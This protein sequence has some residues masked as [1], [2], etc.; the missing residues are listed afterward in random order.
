MFIITRKWCFYEK[1][2]PTKTIQVYKK[3]DCIHF[4][5]AGDRKF[6]HTQQSAGCTA[7]KKKIYIYF[8]IS[9]DVIFLR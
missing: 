2:G 6:Q 9:F 3:V 4:S 5:I 1:C 7:K 8:Y